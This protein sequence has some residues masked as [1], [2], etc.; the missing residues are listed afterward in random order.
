[1]GKNLQDSVDKLWEIYR[2]RGNKLKWRS[3]EKQTW[4]MTVQ[5]GISTDDRGEWG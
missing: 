5:K 2:F 1:M 4:E 3:T